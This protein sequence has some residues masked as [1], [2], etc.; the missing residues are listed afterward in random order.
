MV[1]NNG[2]VIVRQVLIKDGKKWILRRI[3]MSGFAGDTAAAV[4]LMVM[5]LDHQYGSKRWKWH[6][7]SK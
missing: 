6:K 3:Q 5:S 1:K 4:N 2:G 7:T